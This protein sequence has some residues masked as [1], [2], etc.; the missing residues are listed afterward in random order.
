MRATKQAAAS[1]LNDGAMHAHDARR[2]AAV[3][4]CYPRRTEK[5]TV[6]NNRMTG[7]RFDGESLILIAHESR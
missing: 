6:R 2:S 1:G 4:V 7:T 3:N 5:I